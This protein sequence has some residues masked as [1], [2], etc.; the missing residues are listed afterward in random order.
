MSSGTWVWSKHQNRLIPKADYLEE[1]ATEAA[2]ARSCLPFPM[3]ISDQLDDMQSM[4]DGHRYDSKRA[5][6][7]AVLRAGCE[8][9][10]NEDLIKHTAKRYDEKAHLNSI[11]RDV[12]QAIDQGAQP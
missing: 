6:E 12:V 9:V 1:Q 8:V 5:Y 3:I 4:L 11:A 2:K 10:G 7:K